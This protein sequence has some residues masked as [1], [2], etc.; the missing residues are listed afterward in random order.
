MALALIPF[1]GVLVAGIWILV[2]MYCGLRQAYGL[3]GRGSL[4][5]LAVFLLLQTG[6]AMILLLVLVAAL[7]CMGL[8]LLG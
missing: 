5:T 1:F 3:S 6:M 7:A 4:G 2:L 8:L